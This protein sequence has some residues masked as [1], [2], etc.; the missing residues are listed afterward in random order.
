MAIWQDL[1]GNGISE[2][3]EVMPLAGWGIVAIS[4]GYMT[5][6]KRPDRIA[7]SP[8]GVFFR[9]GSNRPTYDVILH[10]AIA[11]ID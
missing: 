10:P 5:E 7:F 1:N 6:M 9:D 4:C 2:R 11:T 3:G 8:Q